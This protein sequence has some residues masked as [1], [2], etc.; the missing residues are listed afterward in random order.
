MSDLNEREPALASP[1]KDASLSS[2]S[3]SS[4]SSPGARRPPLLSLPSLYSLPGLTSSTTGG[5]EPSTLQEGNAGGLSSP[6]HSSSSQATIAELA[7]T[8][9]KMPL[10]MDPAA[11]QQPVVTSDRSQ[12]ANQLPNQLSDSYLSPSLDLSSNPTSAGVVVLPESG[13]SLALLAGSYEEPPSLVSASLPPPPPAEHD[14]A[15]TAET[16]APPLAPSNPSAPPPVQLHGFVSHFDDTDADAVE[17]AEHAHFNATQDSV[18]SD[19]QVYRGSQPNR[20]AGFSTIFTAQQAEYVENS[21]QDGANL[22]FFADQGPDSDDA[23]LELHAQQLEE[24]RSAN[25]LVVSRHHTSHHDTT[26]RSPASGQTSRARSSHRRPPSVT[27]FQAPRRKGDASSSSAHGMEDSGEGAAR[28]RARIDPEGRAWSEDEA[29]SSAADNSLLV[30]RAASPSSRSGRHGRSSMSSS[31]SSAS[32]SSFSSSS[33]SRSSRELSSEAAI[34]FL[35]ANFGRWTSR[36]QSSFLGELVRCLNPSQVVVMSSLLAPLTHCDFLVQLPEEIVSRILGQLDLVSLVRAERV[37]HA[38]KTVIQ[39]SSIWRR[40]LYT[41]FS[42]SIRMISMSR[43]LDL[44]DWRAKC[45]NSHLTRK[46]AQ[47]NW[48]RGVYSLSRTTC[49]SSGVYCVHQHERHVVSG[50]RDKNIRVWLIVD[51]QLRRVRELSGHQGSVLALQCDD[52]RIVSASS[53][54]TVRLW[55]MNTGVQLAAFETHTDSVLQVVFDNTRIVSA[56]KDHQIHTLLWTQDGMNAE[57]EH[58]ITSGGSAINT[59]DLCDNQII[60]ACGDRVVRVYNAATGALNGAPM[61]GHTRG[62][63][64]LCA[65]K[66]LCATGASD[67]L[68]MLWNMTTRTLVRTMTGHTDLVRCLRMN[69]THLVSG[70]YDLTVRVWLVATGVCLHSFTEHRQRVVS[71]RF[72]LTHI[73]SASQD[74]SIA[75]WSFVDRERQPL[76]QAGANHEPNEVQ[77]LDNKAVRRMLTSPSVPRAFDV[78]SSMMEVEHV[79]PD[80]ALKSDDGM[81]VASSYSRRGL[82][83]R[84]PHR[85]S[86]LYSRAPSTPGSSVSG[87]T[88]SRVTTIPADHDDDDDIDEESVQEIEEDTSSIAG[89]QE[90]SVVGMYDLGAMSD[91]SQPEKSSAA[92]KRPARRRVAGLSKVRSS[93][94]R[95]SAVPPLTDSSCS[96]PSLESKRSP[97]AA[98]RSVQEHLAGLSDDG[99]D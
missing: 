68:I 61:H 12:Q 2:S 95:P 50:H 14:P 64:C 35:R 71:L 26:A 19:S 22:G 92:V 80:S 38:W 42:P 52:R 30:A 13:E 28:K 81:S 94:H 24:A 49:R 60:A 54:K 56:S 17:L 79:A 88:R 67:R 43:S 34:S 4:A 16:S 65:H 20:P 78:S 66:D 96:L 90:S 82:L 18:I 9:R 59:V 85:N 76:Y 29:L 44:R 36:E 5:T 73:I 84:S 33:S 57:F 55:N 74:D 23:E 86:E 75:V 3:P 46:A 40:H 48:Q 45:I 77:V 69:E 72:D 41:Q 32:S 93:S 11:H 1:S 21:A 70:S 91:S 8:R 63:T 99:E 25:S 7:A 27:P 58:R 53:D 87:S 62:I 97:S 10:A 31:A 15:S 37:C 39:T 6:S 83:L 98:S 89:L 47:Q 51:E